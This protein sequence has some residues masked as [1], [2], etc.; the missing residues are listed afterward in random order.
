MGQ[1][2]GGAKV[3]ILTAMPS[4]KGLFHKAVVLSGASRRSGDKEFSEKL[5]AAVLKEAGL[6]AERAG[7]ASGHALERFLRHCHKAQQAV[8][9]EAGP[10]GGM[11][12]G[13]SPVVD[14][15]ILP[16]HPYDPEAAPTAAGVPMIISSVQDEMS[17]SWADSSLESITTGASGGEAEGEGRF[18]RRLRR[19]GQGRRRLLRRRRFR[20]RSPWRSGRSPAAT[21]KAWS[22]WRM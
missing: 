22:H 9:R 7:Q 11:M 4:A 8:A 21:G 12:R 1:S 2:G 10:G 3:C 13:F 14:G 5:G 15:N 17:P 18:R 6:N 20:A 16:Q 19:Q